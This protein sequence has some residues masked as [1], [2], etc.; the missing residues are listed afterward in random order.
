MSCHVRVSSLLDEFL[1]SL[2]LQL[3]AAVVVQFLPVHP[4][5][6]TTLFETQPIVAGS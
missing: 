5:L 4:V 3:P 6:A 2:L 1:V